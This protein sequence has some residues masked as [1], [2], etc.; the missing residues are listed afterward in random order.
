MKTVYDILKELENEPGRNAKLDILHENKD[1]DLLRR[2]MSLALN[3]FVNYYQRKIPAF[4]AAKVNQADSLSYALDSLQMLSGRQVTGHDAIAYLQK[5]LSSLTSE[6]SEVLKRVVL[7][8]LKC[9]ASTSSTNATWPGLI[10]EFPVM[11]CSKFEQ[12]LVDKIKW[13]AV[14]QCKADGMRFNAIVKNGSCEFFSRSGK[15][16]NLLGHLADKFISLAD[17]N[18]VVFDGELL[19]SSVNGTEDRQTGNGILNKAVKGTISDGEASR[20]YATVWDI[21][22]FDKF[23]KG[24][25]NIPYGQ[26]VQRLIDTLAVQSDVT[27]KIKLVEHFVVNSYEEAQQLFQ[28]YLDSGQEGIILK[29]L[30]GIWEDKRSKTQIKFKAEL[31]CD[32]KI[33]GI[34]EGSG[35]YEGMLGALVCESSDGIVK[36]SVG[37]GLSDE[38]R[39]SLS[40]EIIGKV[41][42]VKYNARIKNQAG[43]QSLF[44][45]ILLEIR[46]DKLTAD[47]S[48]DIKG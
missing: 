38:Q 9:G 47:S 15:E 44:L 39:R 20:V 26:R 12:R 8:D 22:P 2:V 29:D 34:E 43:A 3:P 48:T 36:V 21:I 5:L 14:V 32:L 13:P 1:N 18:N 11:L 31:D 6:D 28:A 33:V 35:K 25:Y 19:V 42:A 4:T 7:K 10:P 46:E 45:P 37:S 24:V 23:V 27:D 40:N 16:V 41:V 30:S 17:G